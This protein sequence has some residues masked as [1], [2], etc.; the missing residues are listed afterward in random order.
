[1]V[2]DSP[3]VNVCNVQD[4][5]CIACNRTLEDITKWSQMTTE[6][7]LERMKELGNRQSLDEGT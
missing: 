4:G 3:C 2:N 1:M 7:R 5:V 6:E